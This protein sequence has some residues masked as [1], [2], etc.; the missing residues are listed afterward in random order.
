VSTLADVL[1]AVSSGAA[2]P[3]EIG[4]RTGLDPDL[5][6][7]ALVQLADLGMLVPEKLDTGCPDDGCGTCPSTAGCS[8]GTGPDGPRRVVALRLG[9]RPD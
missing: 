7:V 3:E 4:S 6:R 2:T 5:V 1:D 8:A 9:R